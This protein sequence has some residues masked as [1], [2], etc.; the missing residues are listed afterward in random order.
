MDALNPVLDS[1]TNGS[2]PE[3]YAASLEAKARLDE[4]CRQN[5]LVRETVL[6]AEE[7]L[8]TAAVAH[9]KA[10]EEIKILEDIQ[11]LAVRDTYETVSNDD[12]EEF[13]DRCSFNSY[14]DLA[15]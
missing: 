9:S 1:R 12:V 11:L 14:D 10:F 3:I 6:I 7:M 15:A 4:L 13:E 2:S 5:P 8:Q